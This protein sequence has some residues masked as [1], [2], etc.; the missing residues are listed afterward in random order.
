ML[1]LPQ[2]H[3][4]GKVLLRH[5]Q[6]MTHLVLFRISRPQCVPTRRQPDGPVSA[7]I[8]NRKNSLVSGVNVRGLMILR[9]DTKSDSVE[10]V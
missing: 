10:Q 4:I 2:F 6:D 7:Q 3:Q 8:E 1:F 9:V 5:P